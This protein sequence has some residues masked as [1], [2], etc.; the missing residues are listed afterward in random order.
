[1]NPVA[2]ASILAGALLVEAAI[3]Y[4]EPLFHAVRHPV[5]WVGSMLAWLDRHLNREDL[6][7]WRGGLHGVLALVAMAGGAIVSALMV[8]MIVPWWLVA[9]CCELAVCATQPVR[10]CAGGG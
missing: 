9:V 3:G 8:Q 4:P 5:V 2:N 10:A 7:A 6:T 1:M